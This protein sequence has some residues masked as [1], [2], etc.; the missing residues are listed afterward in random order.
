MRKGSAGRYHVRAH[1]LHPPPLPA[2]SVSGPRPFR[3]I[4]GEEGHLYAASRE[5]CPG[6]D[7]YQSQAPAPRPPV[8]S[9]PIPTTL[10]DSHLGSAPSTDVGVGRGADPS[11]R[12]AA[13]TSPTRCRLKGSLRRY[14]ISGLRVPQDVL[15]HIVRLAALDGQAPLI[16][17]PRGSPG[18]GHRLQVPGLACL[19]VSCMPSCPTISA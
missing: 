2:A 7:E 9:T 18:A 15:P 16:S 13:Q 14:P 11:W 10:S 8:P 19:P 1:L 6:E 3:R 4:A 5:Q 17:L 12:T